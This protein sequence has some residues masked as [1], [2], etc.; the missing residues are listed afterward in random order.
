M[1]AFDAFMDYNVVVLFAEEDMPPYANA[2][3]KDNVPFLIAL[4]AAHTS[5][6]W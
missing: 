6:T 2:L 5:G 1:S 4:W 3:S